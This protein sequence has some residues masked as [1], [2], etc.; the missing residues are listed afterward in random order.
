MPNLKE[1]RNRI[2]S[3]QSTRQITKAMKLV[4]ATKLRRAQMAIV[5]MRPYAEKLQLILGNLSGA[6]G[7]DPKL[8]AYFDNRKVNKALVIVVT[9]DRGLCGALN[10]NVVKATRQII[11]EKYAALGADVSLK[12]FGKKAYD[13]FK[14]T[15]IKCDTRHM[16]LF[17]DLKAESVFDIT[18]SITN[19]FISGKFDEVTIIYN[20]FKNAATQQ[21]KVEKVF[22]VTVERFES[23][24][25]NG[26]Q[27]FEADYIFE[28]SKAAILYDLVPRAVKTQVY[29]SCLDAFA[30]EHG[31]RMV[32]MD[33]ATE[34]AG[35]LLD[36]LQLKYN[37]ARQA[38]ITGEI[39]EIVG[40]ASALEG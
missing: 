20:Q 6:V 38:A 25:K 1:V 2:A 37:Q 21:V 3:T 11:A 35:E 30:S 23:G 26:K 7:D 24:S 29:K 12:F 22:P 28:P 13:Q 9:S 15:D 40:G 19:D 27:A 18:E 31:A 10:A 39:L 32:A 17:N 33:K 34:N 4:S 5:K 36:K 16:T 14:K 8:K